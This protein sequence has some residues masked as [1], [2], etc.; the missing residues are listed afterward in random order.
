MTSGTRIIGNVQASG[1]DRRIIALGPYCWGAGPDSKTALRN[2]RQ[3]YSHHYGP[4]GTVK[5]VLVDAPEETTVSSFDGH[6]SWPSD[7]AKPFTLGH[8]IWRINR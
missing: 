8:A 4:R 2:A 3:N 1:T 7:K 5:V 6:L